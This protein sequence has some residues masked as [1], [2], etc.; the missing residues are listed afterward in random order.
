MKIKLGL[1]Q[2]V[3]PTFESMNKK[4]KQEILDA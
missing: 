1:K 3:C 4:T 2:P